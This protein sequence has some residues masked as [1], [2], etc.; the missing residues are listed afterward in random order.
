M[1]GALGWES[2]ANALCNLGA[3][4]GVSNFLVL[5]LPVPVIHLPS[6]CSPSSG[7]PAHCH[8]LSEP[9]FSTYPSKSAVI[10]M[11]G[12]NSTSSSLQIDLNRYPLY[13]LFHVHLPGLTRCTFLRWYFLQ[14]G[15]EFN[16]G[17]LSLSFTFFFFSRDL[18]FFLAFLCSR[19]R[20]LHCSS[21]ELLSLLAPYADSVYS[22][23]MSL[24]S[25]IELRNDTE[26]ATE[27]A[28]PAFGAGASF[29]A[30]TPSAPA[31]SVKMV[32]SNVASCT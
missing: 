15:H 28:V 2:M 16:F 11:L 18:G 22:E 12:L 24:F 19:S 8:L 6:S 20:D 25:I 1:V 26:L 30:L 5:L 13:F 29:R 21:D 31:S 4:L 17:S 23:L 7:L 10:L 9:S 32:W 3:S 14:W 27:F